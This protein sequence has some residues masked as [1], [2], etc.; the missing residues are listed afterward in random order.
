MVI[1]EKGYCNKRNPTEIAYRNNLF[2]IKFGYLD[3]YFYLCTIKIS[4]DG[5]SI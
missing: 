2:S 3:N 5:N 1:I 4:K